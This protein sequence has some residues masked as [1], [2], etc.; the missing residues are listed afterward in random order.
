MHMEKTFITNLGGV[1]AVADFL[2]VNPGVVRNW[3]LD[4]RS[5]PWRYRPAL[6]RMAASKCIETPSGFLEPEGRAA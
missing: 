6:V 2:G 4:N 5:I 1:N 3:L